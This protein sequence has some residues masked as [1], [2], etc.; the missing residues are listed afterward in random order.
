MVL[1]ASKRIYVKK[2]QLPEIVYE[3]KYLCLFIQYILNKTKNK[4]R[5]EL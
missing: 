5:D 3:L 2:A 4:I 1:T